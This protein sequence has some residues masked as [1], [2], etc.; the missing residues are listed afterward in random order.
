MKEQATSGPSMTRVDARFSSEMNRAGSKDYGEMCAWMDRSH[1]TAERRAFLSS[2][3]VEMFDGQVMAGGIPILVHDASGKVRTLTQRLPKQ[4]GE[5]RVDAYLITMPLKGIMTVTQNQRSTVLEPGRFGISYTNLPLRITSSPDAELRNLSYHILAP[6]RLVAERL[7][8]A[9]RLCGSSVPLTGG[10]R[11]A[12]ELLVSL[13]KEAESM[14]RR[15]AESLAMAALDALLDTAEAEYQLRIAPDTLT[16]RARS[17]RAVLDYMEFHCFDADLSPLKVANGCG[18]SVRY[19]HQL[20]KDTNVKFGDHLWQRRLVSAHQ[21]L[22]DSQ[23]AQRTV[24]E[25]AYIV[26]FKNNAHFSR[27]F[28]RTYGATPRSIRA[29]AIRNRSE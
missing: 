10:A 15:T 29:A 18:I 24:S 23:F 26:G 5:D 21:Q 19:L 3:D 14:D 12:R 11:V 27:A 22:T 6:G 28:R 16:K 25:I 7:K 2:D 13:Y 9:R 4:I 17:L 8:D 1:F 20:L